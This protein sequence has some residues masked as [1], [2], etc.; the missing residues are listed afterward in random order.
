M[1][2]LRRK[3]PAG[4]DEPDFSDKIYDCLKALATP[5]LLVFARSRANTDEVTPVLA[6]I[7]PTAGARRAKY[8]VINCRRLLVNTFGKVFR[9]PNTHTFS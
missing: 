9:L 6:S 2:R 8:V 1:D 5:N 3:W 4:G 7:T